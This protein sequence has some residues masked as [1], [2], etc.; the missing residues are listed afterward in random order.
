MLGMVY[1]MQNPVQ[2]PPSAHEGLAELQASGAS[3]CFRARWVLYYSAQFG[4]SRYRFPSSCDPFVQERRRDADHQGNSR[5]HDWDT[6][7]NLWEDRGGS[8]LC[9]PLQGHPRDRRGKVKRTE[10]HRWDCSGL[11]TWSGKREKKSKKVRKNG[12]FW[13]FWMFFSYL[14]EIV[15]K[16]TILLSFL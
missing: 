11:S 6:L 4:I 1:R 12:N 14:K 5:L 15:R 10:P 9:L 16:P 13:R 3:L 2:E 7:P 8:P